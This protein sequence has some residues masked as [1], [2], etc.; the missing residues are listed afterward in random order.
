MTDRSRRKYF[1]KYNYLEYEFETE[2][3]HTVRSYFKGT[4]T[5]LGQ[6]SLK[7]FCF[8]LTKE[9]LKGN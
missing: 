1:I 4:N 7:I 6:V 5:N 3:K 8:M 9:F 2:V